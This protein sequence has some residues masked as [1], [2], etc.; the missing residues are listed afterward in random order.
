M[1][2]PRKH[3]PGFR[4]DE[5][6]DCDDGGPSLSSAEN[7][8]RAA[9]AALLVAGAGLLASVFLPWVR[10]GPGHTLHGHALVDT[11]V[12]L[13]N[14]V[15]GLSAARLTVLW[16]VIPA[17]GALLW[18]AVGAL[19]PG[20]IA[21]RVVAVVALIAALGAFLA[22]GHALGFGALGSGAFVALGGGLVGVTGAFVAP[23]GS[24]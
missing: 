20:S 8:R 9:D 2:S 24:R 3:L 15:A 14:T 5:N 13:G 10:H 1:I 6:D 4:R 11:V 7:R 21:A 16:Y 22:F 23:S 12:A 17:A 18:V 19:G